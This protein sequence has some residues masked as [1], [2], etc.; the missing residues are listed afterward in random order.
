MSENYIW[1]FKEYLDSWIHW[2]FSVQ[3]ID[4]ITILENRKLDFQTLCLAAFLWKSTYLSRLLLWR[5]HLFRT[6]KKMPR[7]K[8]TK[9]SYRE[10][11]FMY[12]TGCHTC[13]RTFRSELLSL[14]RKGICFVWFSTKVDNSMAK[15]I[16]LKIGQDVIKRLKKR[17]TSKLKESKS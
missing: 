15:Y 13:Q 11:T 8:R 9:V 14:F 5:L 17:T 7:K 4:Q 3:K 10:N 12:S 16:A 6:P 1:I 2:K